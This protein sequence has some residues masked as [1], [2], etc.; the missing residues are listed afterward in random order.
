[1]AGGTV[2]AMKSTVV[3][4]AATVMPTAA[5]VMPTGVTVVVMETMGHTMPRCCASFGAAS[6]SAWA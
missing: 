4:T 6:G 2:V 3:P 5:T 1:V